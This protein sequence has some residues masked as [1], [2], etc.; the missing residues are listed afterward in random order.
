MCRGVAESARCLAVLQTEPDS[1]YAT[2]DHRV[3]D[4]AALWALMVIGLEPLFSHRSG[5]CATTL[6]D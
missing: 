6:V 3:R 5:H 1:A 2:H 4:R